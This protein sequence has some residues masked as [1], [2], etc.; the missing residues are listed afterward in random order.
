M[1]S[2]TPETIIELKITQR[3]LIAKFPSASNCLTE[4]IANGRAELDIE[5]FEDPQLGQKHFESSG[6]MFSAALQKA[7]YIEPATFNFEANEAKDGKVILPVHYCMYNIQSDDLILVG[8]MEPKIEIDEL[9]IPISATLMAKK[10]LT[11]FETETTRLEREDFDER[12]FREK[13]TSDVRAILEKFP[14]K[15]SMEQLY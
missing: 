9:K 3:T 8:E 5:K 13:L 1:N 14:T 6:D 2:W 11:D 12:K 15:S 4:I 7:A 10:K